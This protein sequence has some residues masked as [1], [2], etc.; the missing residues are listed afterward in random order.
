MGE[1]PILYL[2]SESGIVSVVRMGAEMEILATN[3]FEDQFFVSSPIV[4][5]GELFLRSRPHL[6]CVSERK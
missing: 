2:A 6:F 3:R 5:E 4:A 1:V